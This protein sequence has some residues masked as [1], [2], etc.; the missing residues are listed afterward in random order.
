MRYLVCSSFRRDAF[1][2]DSGGM[3]DLFGSLW[4]VDQCN[5]DFF[6][7]TD[8]ST[9]W[10][11]WRDYFGNFGFSLSTSGKADQ[12][13]VG[14]DADYSGFC[15][16]GSSFIFIRFWTGCR[17]DCYYYL[18]YAADGAYHHARFTTGFWRSSR[19]WANGR[20]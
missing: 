14:Y 6:F 12:H 9:Y 17:N 10:S 8:C 15:V 16:F 11:S 18:C 2:F 5:D 7:Y 3:P 4:S 1:S 13:F 19:V 20:M